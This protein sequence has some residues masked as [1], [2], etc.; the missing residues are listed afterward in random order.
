MKS[1]IG[2]YLVI[3][4]ETG[5]LPNV[6][7]QATYDV[8]ISEMALVMVDNEL[9]IIDKDSFYINPYLPPQNYTKKAFEV[10][11]STLEI[12]EKEGIPIE[13]VIDRIKGFIEV[14][15][16]LKPLPVLVGQNIRKFDL[17]FLE[18]LFELFGDDLYKSVQSIVFDTLE[19]AYIMYWEAPNYKLGTLCTQYDID[20]ENAHTALAD[21]VAT[22][23]LWISYTKM[24][25]GESES[26]ETEEETEEETKFEF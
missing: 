16:V 9:N 10:N 19:F 26:D 11:G 25:R 13:E 23:E 17:Q 7:K 1:K 4:L 2:S 12:L 20:L 22:A 14:N 24:L 21:T 5:G 8:P 18:N 15:N 6:N 3:D